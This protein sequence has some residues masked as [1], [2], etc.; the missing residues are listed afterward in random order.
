[1]LLMAAAIV[2][3][4]PLRHFTIQLL[5]FPYRLVHGISYFLVHLPSLPALYHGQASLREQLIQSKL[6]ITRLREMLRASDAISSLLKVH[7]SRSGQMAEVIGRSLVPTQ[8][9]VLLN[10]GQQH[11]LQSD[12]VVV[13]TSGVVGRVLELYSNTCLVGLLTDTNSRVASLVE[14]SRDMGL[15]VGRGQGTCEL[16]YLDMQADIEPGDRIL[17][18]GLG[19]VFPKGLLLGTVERVMRDERSGTAQAKVI[20]A[21]Q[22]G[23]L[24]EVWCLP[25]ATQQPES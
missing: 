23:R 2:Y 24:E 14:R 3:H 19:G 22:L 5:R 25:P 11:G 1:M 13:D 7:P 21:A 8:Q 15:L 18:A 4:D 16:I 20:L 9:T 12:S 10:R 6:E 17:T